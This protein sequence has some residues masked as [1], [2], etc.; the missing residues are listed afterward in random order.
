MNWK[1]EYSSVLGELK[2]VLEYL[3]M[4][5]NSHSRNV[6]ELTIERMEKVLDGNSPK[7]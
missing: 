4:G 6:L 1:S 5:E 7:S 3:K 2:A